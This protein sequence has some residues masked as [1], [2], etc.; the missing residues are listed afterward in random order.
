MTVNSILLL[1]MVC[2]AA[3]AQDK[4]K[5]LTPEQ[6][7][8]LKQLTPEQ[9]KKYLAAIADMTP[10]QRKRQASFDDMHKL[11]AVKDPDQRM[12][13]IAAFVKDHPAFMNDGTDGPVNV[14]YGAKDY[15]KA[16]HDNADKLRTKLSAIDTAFP[17]SADLGKSLYESFIAKFL[18]SE[19]AALDYAASQA[20]S[21]I[22]LLHQNNYLESKKAEHA[23]REEYDS[24][25]DKLYIPEKFS[26]DDAKT[27]FDREESLRYATLGSIEQK[28]DKND[29]AVDSF[30]QSLKFH[31]D[32]NAYLGLSQLEEAK[33]DKAAALQNLY[34]ADLT[35]HLGQ[36][37]IV[38]MKQLYAELHPG[39]NEQALV[40]LLDEQYKSTFH[41]P[42]QFTPYVADSARSHRAVLAELFTG[43]GCEPCMSPDLAFDAGLQRYTRKEMVLLVYHDN[44]PFSDPLANNVTEERAKYYVTEGSTPHA[45]LDGTEIGLVQGLPTHAQDSFDAISKSIDKLLDVPAGAD[46]NIQAKRHG[47]KVTVTVYGTIS[48]AQTSLILHID[49]VETEVSY[50]GENTLRFQPMVVRATAKQTPSG[51][52]FDVSDRTRIKAKYTFD[53]KKITAANFAYYSQFDAVLKKRT[54]GLFGAEYREYGNTIDPNKLAAAAFLQNNATKEVLQ[55]AYT[56]VANG[57]SAGSPA[58]TEGQ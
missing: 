54:H 46:F 7:K 23:E 58:T 18:L 52:G 45:F 25:H 10:E 13:A 31:P 19:S 27:D 49:L 51:S 37:G 33:G 4:S 48:K 28:L 41:N 42:V 53:L 9:Q 39:S 11:F 56:S 57:G 21:S 24:K 44:A 14:A 22:H 16:N 32:M 50:S 20:E 8:E 2:G 36:K 34:D 38:H 35:G 30:T 12:D 1:I 55:A 43:A 6:Q 15:I 29:A 47:S 17:T 5:Q 40:S 26:P 3:C